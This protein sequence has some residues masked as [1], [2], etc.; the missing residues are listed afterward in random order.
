MWHS[1]SW[2][3]GRR[4]LKSHDLIHCLLIGNTRWHWGEKEKNS[5]HFSHSYPDKQKLDTL[6]QSLIAWAAVGPIPKEVSLNPTQRIS[7]NNVPLKNLPP[8]LGIDRALAAWSAFKQ[9]KRSQ[10]NKSDLLIADAGTVL[11]LTKIT[12][13]GEFAGGQLVPGLRMQL[14]AMTQG[15]ANL[16][17]PGHHKNKE[18]LDFPV[19]TKEA[20]LKGSLQA[21]IGVLSEAHKLSKTPLWLCGGDAPLLKE[22]LKKQKI[23]II[24]NPNLV[25]EGLVDIHKIVN[26]E[27]G[28]IEFD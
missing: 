27:Q 12:Q 20:M 26:Q 13:N 18:L 23:D 10:N 21:L 28:Q 5:W 16:P 2:N 15:T 8:S 22:G 19:E 9:T 14:A 11:S 6:S 3:D 1:R 24:H 4:D 25:L 17:D 7:I